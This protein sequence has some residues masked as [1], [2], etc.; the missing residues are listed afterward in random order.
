MVLIGETRSM[1]RQRKLQ[2]SFRRIRNKTQPGQRHA[3]RHRLPESNADTCSGV[4]VFLCVALSFSGSI[5]AHGFTLM[6][7]CL[8]AA[9][10]A[11]DNTVMSRLSVTGAS[12]LASRCSRKSRMSFSVIAATLKSAR[13]LRGTRQIHS[14]SG[15]IAAR[16]SRFLICVSVSRIGQATA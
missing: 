14:S 5:P 4:E 16:F 2:A 12:P 1:S 10:K 15:H 13:L 3:S 9:L 8:K 6:W 11:A 7:P